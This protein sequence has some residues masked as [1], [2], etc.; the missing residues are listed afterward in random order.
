MS[1][2]LFSNYFEDL[3]IYY[4]NNLSRQTRDMNSNTHS[5]NNLPERD[6]NTTADMELKNKQKRTHV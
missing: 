1:D 4:A 3:F 5:K 6:T 2:A